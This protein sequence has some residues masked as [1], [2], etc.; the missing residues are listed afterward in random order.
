MR[1]TART[2]PQTSKYTDRI[3]RRVSSIATHGSRR[4]AA[5]YMSTLALT[6]ASLHSAR[7][8]LAASHSSLARSRL[9]M[10]AVR[11]PGGAPSGRAARRSLREPSLKNVDEKGRPL[12]S[13]AAGE[14]PRSAR[15]ML[16]PDSFLHNFDLLVSQPVQ[17]VDYLVDQLFCQPNLILQ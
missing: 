9:T 15:R 5:P 2:D 12:A 6:A 16:V 1:Q 7:M 3:L 13:L 4:L 17:V 14:T 11:T 8:L 10:F